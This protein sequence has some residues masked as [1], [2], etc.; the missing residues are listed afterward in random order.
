MER[1]LQHDV[2][3]V[4]GVINELCLYSRNDQEEIEKKITEHSYS[5]TFELIDM[6]L[7]VIELHRR[8]SFV[9]ALTEFVEQYLKEDTI[10]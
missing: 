10:L 9:A 3:K 2:G 6:N 1:T 7:D 4:M 8:V 5:N